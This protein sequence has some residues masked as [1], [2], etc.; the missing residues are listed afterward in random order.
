MLNTGSNV[1]P[2]STPLV[3]ISLQNLIDFDLKVK[4]DG[5]ITLHI[6]FPIN[7]QCSTIIVRMILSSKQFVTSWVGPSESHALPRARRHV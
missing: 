2:N 1:W 4:C 5:A 6:W 3:D 7:A